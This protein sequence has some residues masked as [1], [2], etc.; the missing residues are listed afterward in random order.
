MP[1]NTRN[2][3]FEAGILNADGCRLVTLL[4]RAALQAV[5]D[6]RQ[7]LAHGEIRA[8]SRR[9]TSASEILYE[10]AFSLDHKA[11]ESLA[12]NLLELYDY[13]Q[14][15]LLKAN[16]EQDDAPLAEAES[17]LKSLLEAWECCEAPALPPPG[18]G[19]PALAERR[20]VNCL[21]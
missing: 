14:R 5:R 6:A 21:G 3:Y 1:A 2:P 8:R 9:I 12:R 7:H 13:V 15:L 11:G 4:Y 20:P 16:V 19:E 18:A 17:L 10:L